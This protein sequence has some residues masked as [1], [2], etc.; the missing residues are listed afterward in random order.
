[1]WSIGE[2]KKLKQYPRTYRVNARSR[3]DLD[4]IA[5][6]LPVLFICITVLYLVGIVPQNNN[7]RLPGLLTIC[8]VVGL[9]AVFFIGRT[10]RRVV[11]YEDG[12]EILGWKS[13]RKLTRSEI[14][15]RRMGRLAWQAGGGSFYIII[16]R[17]RTLRELRLP[18]FLHVDEEFVSWMKEISIIKNDNGSLKSS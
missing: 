1:M 6:S 9:L 10:H 18:P 14:L 4:A 11:L 3:R 13:A 16:P 5:V 17:D 7:V 15:G 12:I 2:Q 8:F